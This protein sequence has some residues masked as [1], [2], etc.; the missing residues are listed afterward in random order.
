[1]SIPETILAACIAALVLI[2]FFEFVCKLV[3]WLTSEEV[4][5]DLKEACGTDEVDCLYSDVPERNFIDE[6]KDRK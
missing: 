4:E 3:A 6:A 1:M 2:T 5:R